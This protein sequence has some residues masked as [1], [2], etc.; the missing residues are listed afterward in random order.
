MA[1][2]T[3][4]SQWAGS[5]GGQRTW[6]CQ[7]PHSIMVIDILAWWVSNI[8]C[9]FFG[10]VS[11]VY[12]FGYARGLGKVRVDGAGSARAGGV[13]RHKLFNHRSLAVLPSRLC[14]LYLLSALCLSSIC[15]GKRILS[16]PRKRESIFLALAPCLGRGGI[17]GFPLPQQE[18]STRGFSNSCVLVTVVCRRT[19]TAQPTS[20]F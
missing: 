12:V 5:A 9:R 14:A 17:V 7:A 1:A 11:R 4:A 2:E 19:R 18:L 16:F 3:G 13:H 20:R 6:H 10:G 15:C 8:F